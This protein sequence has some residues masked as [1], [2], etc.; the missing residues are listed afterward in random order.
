MIPGGGRRNELA[1]ISSAP[2]ADVVDEL[3]VGEGLDRAGAEGV[4]GVGDAVA[5]RQVRMSPAVSRQMRRWG[6]LWG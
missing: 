1:L 3:T 5:S 6:R 2:G 4:G